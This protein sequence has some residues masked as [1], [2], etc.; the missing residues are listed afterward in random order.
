LLSEV[1]GSYRFLIGPPWNILDLLVRKAVR[2]SYSPSTEV[3][4]LM[5]SFKEMTNKCIRIGL[6][7]DVATLRRLSLLSYH[8]L[9][10]FRVPSYYRLCAVS[11]AAGI[12]SSRKKSVKRGYRTKAPYVKRPIL[13]SCYGFKVTDGALNIPIGDRLHEQIPLN[14]HTLEVLSDTTLKA[15]SFTL[16]GTSLSVSYSKDVEEVK[17]LASSVGVDRNLRNL[18]V[19]DERK[20]T[21]YGMAKVVDIAE[22]TKSVVRSFKRNDFRVRKNI[23]SKYGRRRHDRIQNVLHKVSKMVVADA[24]KDK[25]IIAFEDVRHIKRLYRKGNGQARTYRG[26]MNNWPYAEIKRQ[27]EYKAAW[28]GIPVIRLT[29]AETG[30]TSSNCYRCGERLQG[31]TRDD[32]QHERQLWCPKCEVWLDRDLVAVMNISRKGWVRF[33]HPK[34]E[35]VEAMRGNQTMPVILRVDAS[36][37]RIGR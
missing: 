16:T 32:V 20:V 13:T 12:L 31:A 30:G 34:G 6:A 35:A 28:A 21:Y 18:T 19:G 5:R 22:T 37:G 4:D 24:V 33:A 11:K 3:L 26:M 36:K 14:R 9:A 25:Q 27:T 8:S 7:S 23:S 1:I 10:L 29:K 15:N 17:G 2:Q